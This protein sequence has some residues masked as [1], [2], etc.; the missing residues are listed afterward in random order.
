MVDLGKFDLM[1]KTRCFFMVDD[2]DT[3][4]FVKLSR[5]KA[6]ARRIFF[7][8][9]IEASSTFLLIMYRV[10]RNFV[11][12]IGG[13]K[14]YNTEKLQFYP[15]VLANYSFQIMEPVKI[16]QTSIEQALSPN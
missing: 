14:K 9:S 10:A 16:L 3:S 11:F 5:S 1:Q 2:M 4:S 12:D 8:K 7:S 15:R 6:L 13:K